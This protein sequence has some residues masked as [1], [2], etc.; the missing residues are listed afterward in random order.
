MTSID[1]DPHGYPHG[2]VTGGYF[3]TV[4]GRNFG[5]ADEEP[6]VQFVSSYCKPLLWTSDS[7]VRCQA[8]RGIGTGIQVSLGV[9]K[10]QRVPAREDS[11][12]TYD[13]PLI[14]QLS[15]DAMGKAYTFDF[16]GGGTLTVWGT[17]CVGVGRCV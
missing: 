1:A 14:S 17:N 16:E 6:V 15:A 2:P 7:T 8:P 9:P 11:T 3:V 12:F 10:G 4:L 5:A 13:R